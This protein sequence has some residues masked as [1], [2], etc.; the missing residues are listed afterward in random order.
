MF[1]TLWNELFAWGSER[2]QKTDHRKM[3]KNQIEMSEKGLI[4]PAQNNFSL[5]K[6]KWYVPQEWKVKISLCFGWMLLYVEHAFH[7]FDKY[8]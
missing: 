6:D 5:G 3:R 2:T 1:R 4:C 8:F 7:P